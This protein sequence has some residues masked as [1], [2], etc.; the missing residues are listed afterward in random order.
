MPRETNLLDQLL[1]EALEE[2]LRNE[3]KH[4]DRVGVFSFRGV[5]DVAP[6]NTYKNRRFLSDF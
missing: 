3:T 5:E 2:R 6:C 1:T 4:T